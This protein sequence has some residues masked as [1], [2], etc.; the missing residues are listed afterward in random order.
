[1]F[2]QNTA[3]IAKGLSTLL[4]GQ[5]QKELDQIDS[6]EDTMNDFINTEVNALNN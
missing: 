5:R 1:M 2:I 4:E 6:K 3:S